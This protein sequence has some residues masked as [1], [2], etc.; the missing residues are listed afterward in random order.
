VFP[1]SEQLFPF[2]EH[3]FPLSEQLF[4]FS[5][6]V[7]SPSEQLFPFSEHVFPLSEQLFP[8]SGASCSGGLRA[9][10]WN[11]SALIQTPLQVRTVR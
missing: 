11:D 4:A 1:L 7:F 8:F 2:S 9:P 10:M 3:V 6:L 5:E